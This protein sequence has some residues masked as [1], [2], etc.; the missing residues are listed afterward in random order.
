MPI[1]L[2]K[3]LG[4]GLMLLGIM[5]I[6]G[7]SP[8]ES[9]KPQPKLGKLLIKIENHI[10][11]KALELDTLRYKN[12]LNTAY[13]VERLQ[14]YISNIAL[15]GGTC[16]DFTALD[17]Y[18]LI[19]HLNDPNLGNPEYK[20]VEILLEVPVG[21]YEEF[22]FGIGVDKA[23]NEEGPYT[24]DL[25]F[26][27][28]MNWTWS[29]DYIFMKLEGSFIN[30]KGIVDNYVFHIGSSDYYS[31][32]SLFPSEPLDITEGETTT[33]VL[34]ANLNRF[35]DGVYPIDLNENRTSMSKSELAQSIAKNYAHM[36]SL[37][38]E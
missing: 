29:G 6:P 37:I 23:R 10:D 27:W 38:K 7:C 13:A 30:N 19:S 21:C 24:G 26:S 12:T 9:R 32:Q 8:D 16:G 4:L 1:H 14:Y 35:F 3:Y 17:D 34:Y 15:R 22:K 11:G 33:L 2:N 36:F 18:H 28:N 25:D 31:E 20:D 5:A